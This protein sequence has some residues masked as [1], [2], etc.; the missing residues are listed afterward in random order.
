MNSPLHR[1]PGLSSRL[2]LSLFAKRDDLLPSVGGGNKVRKLQRILQEVP[3]GTDLL[4]TCGSTQSN[5]ARATA[6]AARERGWQCTIV[7][8]ESGHSSQDALGNLM[9]LR[10]LGCEV[11]VRE[12]EEFSIAIEDVRARAIG[13]GHK[14]YVIPGGA[15]CLAG[16]LAYVDAMSELQ[17]QCGECG[18]WPEY[19]V[20]ASGTGT[21]QA[22]LIA[23]SLAWESAPVVIGVSVARSS[24]RG[25]QEVAASVREIIPGHS[26]LESRVFFDDRW[27]AGGYGCVDKHTWWAISLAARLDGLILDP[28]YT[29][30]A[31]AG[32]AG[33]LESG[34]LPKGSRVLF[35]HTG[36]L[37]NLMAT[38]LPDR[39]WQ[40]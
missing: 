26:E 22:G 12:P 8:H 37:L 15:H 40:G 5:H 38:G 28:F 23:G 34:Q 14:P 13:A 27:T 6:I 39:L 19:V 35:W 16:A 11:L 32:L 30:K 10:L 25:R 4:I 33:L 20:L 18:W 29:G 21:T 36:G 2:D 31:M 17:R 1:L 24:E 3:V 9:L 7:A